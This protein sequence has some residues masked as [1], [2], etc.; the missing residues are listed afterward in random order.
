MPLTRTSA[1]AA[2]NFDLNENLELYADG[3]YADYKQYVTNRLKRVA[4][5]VLLAR[6]TQ[7]RR[8]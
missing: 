4:V 3:I 8:G 2:V 1:Y 6:I 5:A 7:P